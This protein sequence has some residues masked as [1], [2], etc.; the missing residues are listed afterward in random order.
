MLNREVRRRAG[1]VH[2]GQGPSLPVVQGNLDAVDAAAASGVS[3]AADAVC[4]FIADHV[5]LRNLENFTVRR[6]GDGAIDTQLRDD[7]SGCDNQIRVADARRRPYFGS[8]QS[9][10]VSRACSGVY[11]I[12]RTLL[13]VAKTSADAGS[14][15]NQ[16]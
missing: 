4:L 12:G 8:Y 7:V 9:A 1:G 15:K 13:S 2:V 3:V 6:F 16:A 11:C 14:E 10:G 5:V